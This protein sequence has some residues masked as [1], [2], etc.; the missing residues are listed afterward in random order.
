MKLSCERFEYC[1]E[2]TAKALRMKQTILEVPVDYV[3][4]D[5]KA[6]KKIRWTD[7]PIAFWTLIRYRFKKI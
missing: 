3:P 7:A 4:R 6:G 1:P 5:K 2:V